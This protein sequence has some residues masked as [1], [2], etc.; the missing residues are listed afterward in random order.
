MKANARRAAL[1]RIAALGAASSIGSGLPAPTTGAVATSS[2]TI[3]DRCVDCRD[4]AGLDP[5]GAAPSDAAINAAITAGIAN[6]LPVYLAGGTYRIANPLIGNPR[7]IRHEYVNL[8]FS[9]AGGLGSFD[10]SGFPSRASTV[11]APTFR[12]RPALA[13][14]L[15]S[16]AILKDFAIQGL[17][18]AP[19]A[20]VMPLDDQSLYIGHECRN[21]RHSPYCAIA[22]D[23]FNND[24]IAA[25]DRYPGMSRLYFRQGGGSADITLEN[26]AIQNFVVGIAYGVSGL[27][28]NTED[29]LFQN[30]GISRVDTGYA[31]GHS[32]ARHCMMQMGSLSFARQGIDGLSYGNSTGCPPKFHRVNH[33]YLYRIFKMPNSVGGFVLDDNYAESIRTLGNFGV[34]S[35]YS[36]LPLSF[37]GGEYT[38]TSNGEFSA[39]PPFLLETYS[40]TVFKAV[41]LTRDA[42]AT[43]IDALNVI[44]GDTVCAFE[45]CFLPGSGADRV[46][47]FI[48]VVKDSSHGQCRVTDCYV[49]SVNGGAMVMSDD[50]PRSYDIAPFAPGGRFSATYQSRR[51]TNSNTEY[52]YQP[53]AANDVQIGVFASSLMLSTAG[54][55]RLHFTTSDRHLLAGDILFWMMKPQGASL[56][57]WIVPALKVRSILGTAVIADLLFDPVQYD[58]VAH[59]SVYNAG[60]MYIAVRQWAPAQELT[61]TMNDSTTIT[62]LSPLTIL[63]GSSPGVAG[64]WVAGK[65]VPPNTRVVSVDA[66]SA[67]AV[68]SQPTTGGPAN[69]VKLYFG[70][71]YSAALTPAF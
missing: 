22:I 24:A 10:P 32:Q 1:Q 41:S 63:I 71:L 65:G 17:N 6:H 67:S 9:G 5:T 8:Q 62:S 42:N 15:M 40:P 38:I 29:I 31:V 35:G 50:Y 56:N 52:V 61:C 3:R 26:I 34:G 43:S 45:Q 48:G 47:P 28:A 64:D 70:R 2:T 14:D 36:R 51:V 57:Q 4:F 44:A 68:L 30:V 49:A 16:G 66:K 39:P 37:M 7:A 11:I 53:H 33:G 54:K 60:L 69:R 25:A 21:N 58:S 23:A 20:L 55:G 13:L 46:P 19:N 12:D 27:E 18:S 59:W